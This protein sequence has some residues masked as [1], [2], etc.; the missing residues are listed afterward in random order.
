[1]IYDW[2]NLLQ[3]QVLHEELTLM[4]FVGVVQVM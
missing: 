3:H 2:R 1:M 4:N